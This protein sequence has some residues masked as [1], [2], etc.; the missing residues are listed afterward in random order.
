MTGAILEAVGPAAL[1]TD[2]AWGSPG[3]FL[4]TQQRNGIVSVHPGGTTDIQRVRMARRI[5]IGRATREAAG[6]V[7]AGDA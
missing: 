6:S 7:H 5:G 1:T 2:P 4:E 3:G